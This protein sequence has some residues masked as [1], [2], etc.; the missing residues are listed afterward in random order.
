MNRAITLAAF[1]IA[2]SLLTGCATNVPDSDVEEGSFAAEEQSSER[3]FEVIG[4]PTLEEL[5]VQSD[6]GDIEIAQG[7]TTIYSD[8]GMAGANKE[9]ANDLRIKNGNEYLS[10]IEYTTKVA[11]ASEPVF[12]EAAYGDL[13]NDPAVQESIKFKKELHRQI[14][15]VNYQTYGSQNTEPY[16]QKIAFI[17]LDSVTENSDGTVTYISTVETDSNSNE[18]I[19]EG[20]NDGHQM[21]ATYIVDKSEPVAHLTAP[22]IFSAK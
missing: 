16:S 20:T 7:F 22:A 12:S 3:A 14:L 15:E 2:V 18:N 6:Q 17:S 4:L 8:W 13:V 1:L 21:T 19:V 10:L 9:M 5:Q 11:E